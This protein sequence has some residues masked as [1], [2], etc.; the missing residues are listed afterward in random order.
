MIPFFTAGHV[1]TFLD[2]LII[3]F[4]MKRERLKW[5][6]RIRVGGED[7]E[8]KTR[9]CLALAVSAGRAGARPKKR[10]IRTLIESTAGG[11]S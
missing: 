6:A 10:G 11:E 2:D 3:R 9:P 8:R 1:L 5:K 4:E 7:L